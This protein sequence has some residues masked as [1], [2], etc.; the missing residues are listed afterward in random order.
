LEGLKRSEGGCILRMEGRL[1]AN[2]GTVAYNWKTHETPT[3]QQGPAKDALESQG[4]R[5]GPKVPQALT[6]LLLVRLLEEGDEVVKTA[7]KRD[8]GR[9][10][11]TRFR[12]YDEYNN[13]IRN[14]TKQDAGR[15]E[16]CSS[17]KKSQKKGSES[18]AIETTEGTRGGSSRGLEGNPS[19]WGRRDKT[20]SFWQ[21]C[22]NTS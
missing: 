16:I 18:K 5:Q 19:R 21:L 10:I 17:S 7:Y 6:A 4:K 20:I 3:P 2:N 22:L 8:E 9:A 13:G 12:D 15:K 14:S 11:Y 1:P